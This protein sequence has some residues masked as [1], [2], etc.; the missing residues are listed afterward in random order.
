LG[1]DACAETELEQLRVI[2]SLKA[3][4]LRQDSPPLLGVASPLLVEDESPYVGEL[5]SIS[6]SYPWESIDGFLE[7]LLDD[8]AHSTQIKVRIPKTAADF[9]IV[10]MEFLKE[11]G[12]EDAELTR[13]GP[14]G[15][16][17]V[18][19]GHAIAQAKFHPS[20]KITVEVVRALAGSRQ[21]KDV[22]HAML[23]HYGPGYT[24]DAVTS[25][26]KLRVW[27]FE[28]DVDERCFRPVGLTLNI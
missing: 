20:Q 11:I 26:R 24:A 21:E 2:L 19:S 14:D 22:Q 9:E 3:K 1:L 12:A 15:G 4:E 6:S 25:A 28:L 7:D 5:N 13:S 16:V 10:C 8:P 18:L 27:L 23:F 17:D